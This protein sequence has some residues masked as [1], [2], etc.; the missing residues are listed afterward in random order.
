[1]RQ[2]TVI[3]CL[4]LATALSSCGG[5]ADRPATQEGPARTATAPPKPPERPVTLIVNGE[6]R[7]V[8]LSTVNFPYC[9]KRTDVC[10]AIRGA[11]FRRLSPVGKRAVVE[12]RRRKRAR[13]REEALR[14][15]QAEE[16]LRRQRQA[17]PPAPSPPPPPPPPPQE[18]G[19][20]TG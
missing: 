15:Q 19:T 3:G 1:M 8:T 12:A 14:R 4:A 13:E 20:T 10:S 16:E 11:N 6:K 9:R 17:P 5:D 7:V 2:Q 18:E